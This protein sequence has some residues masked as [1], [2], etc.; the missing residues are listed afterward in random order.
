MT[1]HI[2][3]NTDTVPYTKFERDFYCL[4][5]LS[6]MIIIVSSVDLHPDLLILDYG[7]YL[8]SPIHSL[9]HSGIG[10]NAIT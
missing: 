8:F 4:H 9:L 7:D 2:N 5:D 10:Q 6:I 3:S 1:C